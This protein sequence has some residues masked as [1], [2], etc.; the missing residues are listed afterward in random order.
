MLKSKIVKSIYDVF[1]LFL[2]RIKLLLKDVTTL[3]VLGLL[4]LVF[5]LMIMSM[6]K[7][8][9]DLSSIPVGIID[10]DESNSSKELIEKLNGAK[11]LRYVEKSEGELNKLLMDEM[12][13]AIVVIEKGYEDGLKQGE[14]KNA[15]TMYYKKD[16]KSASIISDIVAGE[17]V[18]PLCLNKCFRYYE[19]IEFTGTKF[20]FQQYEEYMNKLIGNSNDFDFAFQLIYSNPKNNI[21]TED[22]VSNSVL[23]NQL[24]FGILGI[25]IAFVSMFILSQSVREKEIGV[26]D[27]LKISNFHILKRDIANILAMLAIEGLLALVFIGLIFHQLGIDNIGLWISGYFL[28]LLNALVLGGVMQLIA[29]T[30]KR[31]HLYQVFCSVMILL[32]GGL[33][34]YYLLNSFYQGIS[35]NMIKII[36]NSWFIKGFTDIIIYGSEGGYLKESHRI[37][38]IM[39][40]LLLILIVMIDLLQ[41]FYFNKYRTVNVNGQKD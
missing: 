27:R 39:A 12:I 31:I 13:Y 1:I 5:S 30:V 36:P 37:L 41:S 35:E 22:S 20:S 40:T 28:L 18:Y 34:F 38:L 24:I 10:N 4:M 19:N 8:A 33:G 26:E 25:L 17:I 21:V 6:T 16:N 23:Y 7:S 29:K 32:T 3:V 9:E 2:F 11:S 14:L 15:I